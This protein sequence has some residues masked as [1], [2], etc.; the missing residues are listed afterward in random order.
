ELVRQ[1]QAGA[2]PS[3][4]P[5]QPRPAAPRPAPTPGQ[6][7]PTR[8][9]PNLPTPSPSPPGIPRTPTTPAP[10]SI[11]DTTLAQPSVAAAIAAVAGEM[12]QTG[13]FGELESFGRGGTFQMIGDQSPILSLRAFQRAALPP[14]PPP[15]PPPSKASSF[16]ASVRGVKISEN[17]SPAPQDRIFYSFNFFAEV[18]QHVNQRFEASVDGLR[19]YR[20]ILGFEKTFCGGDGSF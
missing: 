7:P 2:T 12:E 9:P 18:N 6:P 14:R 4:R 5:G 11:T 19:V 8:I 17:Q 10:P 15:L 3:P 20:E 13:G 16:V 1:A